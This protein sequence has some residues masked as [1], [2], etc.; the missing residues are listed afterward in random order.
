MDELSIRVNDSWGLNM[1]ISYSTLLSYDLYRIEDLIEF[2]NKKM[3]ERQDG[4]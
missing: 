1:N 3:Q 2:Y 4:N